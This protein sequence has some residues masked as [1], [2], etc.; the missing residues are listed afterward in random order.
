MAITLVGGA[1]AGANNGADATVTLPTLQTDDLVIAAYEIAYIGDITSGL[2]MTTSGYTSIGTLLS[3][4]SRVSNLAAYY[5]F[6]GGSPDT[7]AVFTGSTLTA[8]GTAACVLCFRGVKKVADGGPFDVAKVDATGINGTNP[9]PGAIDWS[10][11]AGTQILFAAGCTFVTD[12]GASFTPPTNYAQDSSSI[13]QS[14]T[15]VGGV[16]LMYRS[17]AS[18]SDPENPGSIDLSAWVNTSDSWGT[19]TMAL[20]PAAPPAPLPVIVRA[21]RGRHPGN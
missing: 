13:I 10:G 4:D 20:A 17:A 18:P 15:T 9:D 16:A 19:F 11:T 14:E 8:T 5:K 3:S 2:A 12:V 6:M 7:T 21:G 1:N